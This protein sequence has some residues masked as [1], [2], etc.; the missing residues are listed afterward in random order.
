M[1]VPLEPRRW[2]S[3]SLHRVISKKEARLAR[4]YHLVP[5]TQAAPV[6]NSTHLVS[7]AQATPAF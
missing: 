6:E 5:F 4:R 1:L 3:S 7:L 2:S